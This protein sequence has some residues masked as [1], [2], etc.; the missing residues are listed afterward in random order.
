MSNVTNKLCAQYNSA[1]MWK[2]FLRIW[3]DIEISYRVHDLSMNWSLNPI[4][5]ISFGNLT[6]LGEGSWTALTGSSWIMKVTGRPFQAPQN[7][8]KRCVLFWNVMIGPL[9]FPVKKRKPKKCILFWKD[10][11]F[12]GRCLPPIII[13]DSSYYCICVAWTKESD[14]SVRGEQ[15]PRPPTLCV[16]NGCNFLPFKFR[17]NSFLCA[18]GL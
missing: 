13:R 8:K 12:N 9:D 1:W 18:K 2:I 3:Y 15:T 5:E 14:K 10:I 16:E 17:R 7:R 4:L 11:N 6:V